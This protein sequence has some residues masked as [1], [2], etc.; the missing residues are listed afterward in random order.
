MGDWYSIT[1][2][3]IVSHPL[4]GHDITI[5]AGDRRF[6]EVER[7]EIEGRPITRGQVRSIKY[8]S[9]YESLSRQAHELAQR[10][11]MLKKPFPITIEMGQVQSRRMAS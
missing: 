6:W 1:I 10:M 5:N 11:I 3:P 8:T 4:R 7:G 9:D 2:Y